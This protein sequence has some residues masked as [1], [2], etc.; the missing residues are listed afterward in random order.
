M[1][2]KHLMVKLNQIS[3]QYIGK[4]MY[5]LLFM[6]VLEMLVSFVILSPAMRLFQ[7]GADGFTLSF[8]VF[9]LA[10][11]AICVW[12]TFQFGF[13]VMLLQMTRR[14]NTNLGYIFIGFKKINP[15]G[16]VIAVFG[17]FIALLALISRFLA[18]FIYI[19]IF[20]DFSLE[21]PS[22]DSL[23][24]VTENPELVSSLAAGILIFTGFFLAV[25]FVLALIILIRFVFVFH[26]HFDNPNLKIIEVFR[27]SAEMMHK[28]VIRL[29]VFALR[30][31]G[32]QLLIAAF[33]AVISNFIP[34][35]KYSAM[36]VLAFIISIAYFVN[37]YTAA[38]RIYLTVPV[39]YEEIKNGSSEIENS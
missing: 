8:Y 22:I 36:S 13:T 17:A 25:L 30:A 14:K 23:Q 37:L 28:N 4:I 34:E 5:A 15:A 18:K 6:S 38:I 11:I 19:K 3:S 39:L 31:G 12:L 7:S 1:N 24:N 21:A 9:V 32:K 10:F 27:K 29:I 35:E 26:L 20:P 33:L 2:I 16:K